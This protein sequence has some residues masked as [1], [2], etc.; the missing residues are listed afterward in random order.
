MAAVGATAVIVAGGVTLALL[1]PRSD[2]VF[3]GLG[4]GPAAEAEREA[5]PV[6]TVEA[7]PRTLPLSLSESATIVP[8]PPA[9]VSPSQA[10]W[11][12]QVR[13]REGEP[14]KAGQVIAMVQPAIASGGDMDAR[15]EMAVQGLGAAHAEM[16]RAQSQLSAITSA[17]AAA[18]SALSEGKAQLARAQDAEKSARAELGSA[19]AAEAQAEAALE[20]TRSL[21]RQGAVS[22]QDVDKAQ[23]TLAQAAARKKQAQAAFDDA[24]A[25]VQAAQTRVGAIRE[26]WGKASAQSEQARKA[27]KSARDALQRQES[28]VHQLRAVREGGRMLPLQAPVAGRIASLAVR[29]GALVTPAMEVARVSPAGVAVAV[30]D[31]TAAQA[32]RLRTGMP[33]SVQVSGDGR[34]FQGKIA[35]I[36]PTGAGGQKPNRVFIEVN[37]PKGSLKPGMSVTVQVALG[38]VSGVAIPLGSLVQ[39]PQGPT[40]WVVA[41]GSA[42]VRQVNVVGSTQDLAI[43]DGG[44]AGGDAVVIRA[45]GTL[46]SGGAVSI[47]GS[48]NPDD[49]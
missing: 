6:E 18:E 1:A 29:D 38:K 39:G 35:A 12:R 33:A 24:E 31:V 44:L 14:V 30:F 19:A 7:A 43:V 49:L 46:R 22:Q 48:W 23:Q 34:P 42:R 11:V 13:V 27:S 9:L 25:Q 28:A 26:D 47:S 2:S 41:E 21:L 5:V 45:A 10:C 15:Y 4:A 3:A 17:M 37:D 8:T 32:L 36:P 40:V 20:E 16:V